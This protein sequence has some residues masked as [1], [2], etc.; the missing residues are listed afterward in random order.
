MKIFI[1]PGHGGKDPGAVGSGLQEKDI[2][3]PLALSLVEKLK[4]YECETKL[5]RDKDVYVS[6]SDRAMAANAWGANLFF[7][8]HVNAFATPEPNGYEDYTYPSVGVATQNIRKAIH[9]HIAK[10]WT[11]VSR[12]NRG[13][14][15]K[16]LQVL[17]ETAMP[18]VLVENGFISNPQDAALLKQAAFQNKLVDA[19]VAGIAE[20]LNLKHKDSIEEQLRK[21]LTKT[22]QEA[23]RLRDKLAQ[24]KEIVSS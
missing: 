18:A 11:A 19:M 1:D 2:V 20:A 15:T 4:N 24:I 5:S 21:E 13:M 23:S 12:M 8:I 9:L 17:R 22:Q 3:L 10:V 7:S 6:L 16:N 14:K